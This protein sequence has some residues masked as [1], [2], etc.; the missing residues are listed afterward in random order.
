MMSF[1]VLAL[2]ACIIL[3][4]LLLL[5]PGGAAIGRGLQSALHNTRWLL[6]LAYETAE[7]E[8]RD[9]RPIIYMMLAVLA[10][11]PV[12]YMFVRD[13]KYRLG[14]RCVLEAVL[15]PS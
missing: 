15:T 2:L 5:P 6:T 14:M 1:T 13:L 7:Y 11:F 12:S 4:I 9:V 3:D 10:C 8:S